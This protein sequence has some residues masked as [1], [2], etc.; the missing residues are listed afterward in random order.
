MSTQSEDAA[1]TLAEVVGAVETLPPG[2]WVLAVSGGRD[3][4]VL[5]H[6][7]AS[8]R[9]TEVGAVATFDHGTGAAATAAVALVSREAARLGFRVIAGRAS[10]RASTRPTEAAWRA[11]RWRFLR[12]CAQE[13][14][15]TVVTA[16][17]RDDQAETVALRILR[18]AGPRGLAGMLPAGRVARPLLAVGR[19]TIAQ[20]A[21]C[22]RVPFV[23]DPSNANLRHARNRMRHEILPAIEHARPGFGEW[24][25]H[26]SDRA[27]AWRAGV[28]R[29]ID[30]A[31]TGGTITVRDAHTMV[32]AAAPFRTLGADEWQVLWPAIA[33]RVGLA[34]DRRGVTRASEWAARVSKR[35]Q[36]SS[37]QLAGGAVIERTR[38]TFV[39][40]SVPEEMWPGT[41]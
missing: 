19:A 14:G 25:L 41:T 32:I 35:E 29:F 8:V 12:S 3:S 11:D 24:L 13:F 20:Y 10:S 40:R 31:R 5:M 38:Q 4:M 2:P 15:A 34:M 33:A 1:A 30:G 17:S 9:Q 37:I 7:F 28:E 26:L 18:G 16:H 39:L 23:E 21:D 27:S 36:A 6:A 22:E